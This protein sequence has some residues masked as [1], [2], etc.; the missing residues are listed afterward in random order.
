M[1]RCEKSVSIA[2]RNKLIYT[3]AAIMESL[4]L[5]SSPIVPHVANQDSSIDGELIY[6]QKLLRDFNGFFYLFVSGYSVKAGTLLFLNNYDLNM[7]TSLWND[8]E[9]FEPLRFISNGRLLKPDH[10]IPF[11]IGRRSCMG[12][13]MVQFLSFSIIGNLLNEFNISSL[14]NEEIKVPLGSLAMEEN[15]YQFAFTL[16]N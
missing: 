1:E 7:S 10:F 15:P 9:K 8:P 11:G 14:N 2:D 3:E 5:I 6:Y 4:R 16:R 13:K 12:Y